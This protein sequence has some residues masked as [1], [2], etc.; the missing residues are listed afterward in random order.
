MKILRLNHV[1]DTT[2]LSRSTVYKYISEGTFPKPIS[3]GERSVG[4]LESEVMDWL[5]ARIEERDLSSIR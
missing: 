5:L 3:L 4:W 1:I 2:G